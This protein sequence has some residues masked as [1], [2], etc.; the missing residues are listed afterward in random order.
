M[1]HFSIEGDNS[2]AFLDGWHAR[3][4]IGY[5]YVMPIHWSLQQAPSSAMRSYFL[6]QR[7]THITIRSPCIPNMNRGRSTMHLGI[8]VCWHWSYFC[9]AMTDQAPMAKHPRSSTRLET[10][11]GYVSSC[12][13]MSTGLRWRWEHRTL[14]ETSE[15]KWTLFT[16]AD[17]AWMKWLT[18]S[19]TFTVPHF[20]A[21]S[22]D[23]RYGKRFRRCEVSSILANLTISFWTRNSRTQQRNWRPRQRHLVYNCTRQP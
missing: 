4:G 13:P 1:S 7:W 9:A 18:K 17:E 3:Q 14:D 23:R 21:G 11:A 20:F 12:N 6:T 22:Q 19:L 8:C 16:S 10:I 15:F 5:I 2:D